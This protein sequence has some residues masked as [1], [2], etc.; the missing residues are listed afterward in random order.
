M[1]YE[2]NRGS[3]CFYWNDKLITSAPLSSKRNLDFY[4]TSAINLILDGLKKGFDLQIQKLK[5]LTIIQ[6]L[7]SMKRYLLSREMEC[8]LSLCI[9]SLIRLKVVEKDDVLMIFPKKK[10]LRKNK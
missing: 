3:V 10:K 1:I 5:Y 7:S 9:L 6:K 4:E 2:G 8:E